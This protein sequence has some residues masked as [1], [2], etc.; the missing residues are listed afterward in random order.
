MYAASDFL[1]I[2]LLAIRGDGSAAPAAEREGRLGARGNMANDLSNPVPAKQTS[3]DGFFEHGAG[4][5]SLFGTV[6]LAQANGSEALHTIHVNPPQDGA[7]GPVVI[8]VEVTPGSIIELPQPFEADAALLAKEGDG[9]LAIRVGDVTVVLQ[10]YIEANGAAPVIIEGADNQPID[11]ATILASTDPAIDIQTAAG[12]ADAGQGA[13]NTGAILAQLEGGNGL[14]G[15]DS[16]GAQDGTELAYRTIDNS[17]RNDF[18]DTLTPDVFSVSVGTIS[19]AFHESFLRDPAQTS[20]F[21]NTAGTYFGTFLEEYRDAVEHPGQ[22]MFAGWADFHGT[23]VTQNNNFDEYLSQTMQSTT[24]DAHFT[25]GTGDLVLTGLGN[26]VK[27]NGSELHAEFKDGGHTMFLRRDDDNALVAVVHV[28]GPDANGHFVIETIMINRIDHDG[29][30]PGDAGKDSMDI[31]VQFKVYDGPAPQQQQEGPIEGG[32]GNDFPQGPTS[33]SID[34]SFKASFS[35]DVPILEKVT[36]HNQHDDSVAARSEVAAGSDIGLI[37]EDWLHGGAKDKGADWSGNAGDNGDTGGGTCVVGCIE[38]NFGADGKAQSDGKTE[39]A[40]KHAFVLDTAQYHLGQ[41]FPY[42]ENGLTSGNKTLVVLSVDGD[43]LTVGIADEKQS[44]QQALVEGAEGDTSGEPT[45]PIP[46]CTIFTLTLDQ[47]TGQFKF[48]LKGPLDHGDSIFGDDTGASALVAGD[49][50]ETIPLQFGVKA[51][52]D[53]GDWV[54]AEI[55]IDVNDDMPV[56]RNDTDHV[57]AGSHD[58]I[59]G[60]VMTGWGTDDPKSGKDSQGGDHAQVVAISA[61]DTTGVVGKEIQG[62]Y[63]KLVLNADGHYSYTRDA[64]TPGGKDDTFTYTLKDGDGDTSTATLTI[65]IDDATVSISLPSDPADTTVHEAGLD[66]R[67]GEAAGSDAASDSEHTEGT[68]TITA[69]DGIKSL[70][71]GG[72]TLTL[73]ELKDLGDHH[74]EITDSTGKLTL[75]GFDEG[76]GALTYTYDLTDN[77]DANTTTSAKF[78]IKVT[79]VDDDEGTAQLVINIV[80]DTPTAVCDE[81]K[82]DAPKEPTADVQ[83]ILDISGSMQGYVNI[84][85]N[86]YPDNGIGLERYS[87][88]QMLD[89]HPEIQN[90]QFVLFDEHAD[91]SDWMTRDEAL[92]WLKDGSNFNG[93]GGNTNYDAA[94]NEAM[95]GLVETRPLPNGDQTLVYFFSDG[96]PNQPHSDPGITDYGN[97]FEVSKDEWQDFVDAHG[98][99]NV[100]AVGIG[101]VNPSEAGHLSPIAYPDG[102][103]GTEPNLITLAGPSSANLGDLLGTLNATIVPVVAPIHGDLTLNDTPGA[104]SFGDGKLVSVSYDGNTLTFADNASTQHIDLGA[105]RGS[106]DIKGDGTYTY[107]PPAKNADGTPFYIEY[108]IQDGDGDTSTAKLK[109]DINTRPETDLNGASCEGADSNAGFVEDHG[110]IKI[111]PDGAVSDDA[112]QIM[113]MTVT[114]TNHPDGTLEKLSLNTDAQNAA[115]AHGL[116]VTAYDP[117]TGVLTISGPAAPASVYQT[118]LQGIVYDNSSNTPNT[119]DRHVTV[120]VNDGTFNSVSHTVDIYVAPTN[121]APTATAL[122]SGLSVDEHASLSIAGKGLSIA[123][124]DAGSDTMTV[125]LTVGEGTLTVSKGSANVS[126][127]GSGGTVTITGS[128]SE[129]NKVLTGATGSMTYKDDTD[130]PSAGTKLTLTVNDNGNNGNGG[131]L[132]TS[133]E[134]IIT[135]NDLNNK[136]ETDLNGNKS[137]SDN[138]AS[139]T[140][141]NGA[142]AISPSGT[143]KDDSGTIASMKVTLS[144]SP[145]GNAESL[146][147]SAAYLPAGV[148]ASYANGVLTITGSASTAAYQTILQHILYNN[149]SQAPNGSDRTATVVVNDGLLNSTSHSVTIEVN[150]VNDAPTATALQSGLTVQAAVDLSLAGKGLSIADID[151]G[152]DTMTVKLTVGEGELTVTKGSANV[153]INTSFDQETVTITGSQ[154][155]INKVLTGV[156]G[157]IVYNDDEYNP[158]TS[159]KLTMTVNDNGN[160][161]DGGSLSASVQTT[162]AITSPNQKPETDL[163]GSGKYG[164]DNSASFT[165]DNGAIAISPSGTVKDDSGTVSSMKVSLTSTPDGSAESLSVSAAYLPAGVTASYAGGVLTITGSAST[166]VYQTILQHILYDNT[167]QA[168]NGADRTVTVVVNDGSLNSTSHSV[169]VEVNPVNDAPTA[170]ALQSGLN[171]DERTSLTIAGKGLSIADIDAGSDTMTVKLTVGEGALT[172]AKGGANVNISGSGGT[173][174]ITGSQAEINKVLTGATGSMTYK[175]DTDTPSASTKLTMTVNDNGNNG[176]GGSLSTSVQTTITIND[177]NENPVAGNDHVYTNAGSAGFNISE[178]ILLNN[179]SDPDTDSSKFDFISGNAAITNIVGATVTHTDG[180]GTAGVVTFTDTNGNTDSS[181]DYTM[182]DGSGGTATGHVTVHQ[183]TNGGTL[184]GSSGDDI[185]WAGPL[186]ATTADGGAGND[187]VVGSQ[188]DDKLDGGADDDLI[189]GGSGNDS[190]VY[191]NDS[192]SSHDQYDGGNGFDRILVT[193]SG[194]VNIDYV[195]SQFKNIDMIDLG[196]GNNRFGAGNQNEFALAAHDLLPNN[197]GSSIGGKSIS[198]FVIGD[199]SGNATT[200]RDIVDLNGFS[201]SGVT[202]NVTDAVTG[203]QHAFTVYSGLNA[204]NQTVHVAIETGLIVH[205]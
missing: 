178:W 194:D 144:S 111:A 95:D 76:T 162:I 201:N 87:I 117:A 147:V 121:D 115:V 105:G 89:A 133:V 137:G 101:S 57:A 90:V 190:L 112:G 128:Q 122:Q 116:T 46:G 204:A 155:E 68:I 167:S 49:P 165:E 85:G 33:P 198:M 195:A 58:E 141:D 98:V 36:Y 38:V 39:E 110:A 200:G 143:V 15:F 184:N 108:T 25:G 56:A 62:L 2:N 61:G 44:Q 64:Y 196:D 8:R 73:A 182:S 170:T 177:T 23:A 22:A 160:N 151:A 30:A 99:S 88:Q 186:I 93:Q 20:P 203:I 124:V 176:D 70:E 132:S 114:L 103:G 11:I 19:G 156:T 17:I 91:H 96:N 166:A 192:N 106:I 127:S 135:I 159:T 113:S 180:A 100:F 152:S 157:S 153:S 104:D 107:N 86:T 54:Q 65:H 202:G 9:N 51:Y 145:D 18:A 78:D 27:S 142:I 45:D 26:D 129:I 119:S 66:V 102:S 120:V 173:V 16:A 69:K 130:T 179:D 185:V 164:S 77:T 7:A 92:A 21:G 163:N 118:I 109:I 4:S 175:D 12:P 188:K 94:L 6:Q 31:D 134:T 138:S 29:D 35:D 169:T 42:G 3:G 131:S 168:P 83:F 72:D 55:D 74:H 1:R 63:G 126:I 48:E 205:T 171:V 10:G 197:T 40:G 161:G 193:G 123:D 32:E 199:E 47:D 82:L 187:I 140:E 28:D 75:T 14:G 5:D 154:S 146:S 60:N 189:F 41:T 125:K 158:S 59:C 191:S 149:T 67:S 53:D 181:F 43:H 172:V 37:D 148:T 52:D 80:D 50:E 71:I 24:V 136:P 81:L 139:F 97:G 183:D 150:P 84:P 13:D 174:T 79:D 34:G